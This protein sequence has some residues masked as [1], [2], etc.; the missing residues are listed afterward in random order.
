MAIKVGI[1]EDQM[2]IAASLAETLEQLGYSPTEPAASFTEAIKMIETE[3]PDIILLDIKLIGKNDGID[4]AHEI[5]DS[6]AIPFIFLTANAD[7]LTLERAK[8]ANPSAFITKPFTRESLFTNIEICFSNYIKSAQHA[9][10]SHDCNYIV[11]DS[12]FIKSGAYFH[13]VTISDILYI[14][15]DDMNVCVCTAKTK[16]ITRSTLDDYLQLI[17]SD[18]FFRIHPNYAINLDRVDFVSNNAVMIG[19]NEIPVDSASRQQLLR[20]LNRQ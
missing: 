1:V 15:S 8:K 14:E 11:N 3:R 13:K 20:H 7:P 2:I 5:R 6:Y 12:I 4:L 17:N 9:S 16:I 10:S 18:R 19:N